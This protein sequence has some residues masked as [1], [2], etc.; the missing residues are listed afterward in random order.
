MI[1]DKDLLAAIVEEALRQIGEKSRKNRHILALFCAGTLGSREAIGQITSLEADG[2]R[3]TSV[4]TPNAERMFDEGEG[5]FRQ[6][7]GKVADPQLAALRDIL[8][9]VDALAIPILTANTAAKISTGVADNVVTE[10]AREWLMRG[11]PIVAVKDSCDPA[12][13]HNSGTPAAYVRMLNGNIAT[14]Q[15]F[16][17]K[18]M[19]SAKLYEE[20]KKTLFG[21]PRGALAAEEQITSGFVPFAARILDSKAVLA[22]PVGKMDVSRN[23]IVTPLAF[24]VAKERGVEIVFK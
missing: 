12:I 7:P 20:L 23:T 15:S 10:L 2:C 1:D 14:L 5:C 19:P 6:I 8:G 3:I 9:D 21:T 13:H 18:M 16:G 11:K 22:A 4:L 24:D 17:V